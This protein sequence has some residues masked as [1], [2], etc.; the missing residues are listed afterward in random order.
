M[1]SETAPAE[2]KLIPAEHQVLEQIAM[3]GFTV[4]EAVASLPTSQGEGRR[5]VVQLLNRMRKR[6]LIR[7]ENLYHG[8]ECIRLGPRGE[9]AMRSRSIPMRFHSRPLSE[10]S[11]VRALAMLSFCT[12]SDVHRVPLCAVSGKETWSHCY[13]ENSPERRMGFLRVDMGGRG[14]WDRILAKCQHDSQS[15]RE[16]PR[17]TESL[18]TGRAELSLAVTLPHK[19]ERLR[20]VL[21][22]HSLPLPLRIIV[23][24]ELL[25]LIAPPPEP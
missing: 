12:L 15:I 16:D 6:R 22:D 10:E 2:V 18:G 1:P 25:Y 17:F 3:F 24:P 19:A 14:R 9:Q 5:G 23:I 21:Q 7:H 4:E 13:I 11:K 20:Q 8:R